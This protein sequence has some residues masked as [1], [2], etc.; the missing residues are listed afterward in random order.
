MP[1]TPIKPPVPTV[2]FA[3]WP[4]IPVDTT[5]GSPHNQLTTL[6][7]RVAYDWIMGP[8]GP[9]QDPEQS[10]VTTVRGAVG[11][12]LLHLM[13][14]GLIDV[15]TD[16]LNGSDSFPWGLTDCRPTTAPA[17]EQPGDHPAATDA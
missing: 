15:D 3:D 11:A 12:A 10:M 2:K 17:P 8:E 4:R 5:D 14:L 16:R 7:R 6:G 13:E 9:Y 1:D